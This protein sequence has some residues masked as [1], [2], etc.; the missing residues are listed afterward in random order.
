MMFMSWSGVGK[1][2]CCGMNDTSTGLLDF[3]FC[4]NVIFFDV[5]EELQRNIGL[6]LEVVW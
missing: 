1:D 6:K 4:W 5:R 2:V 3:E